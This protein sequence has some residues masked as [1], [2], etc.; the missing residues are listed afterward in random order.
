MSSQ[1]KYNKLVDPFIAMAPIVHYT[2]SVPK[3]LRW[4]F[5]IGVKVVL[6]LFAGGG[7]S[8]ELTSG[9]LTEN[10]TRL[11]QI[12]YSLAIQIVLGVNRNQISFEKILKVSEKPMG[13]FSWKTLCHHGQVLL[14]ERFAKFDYG[15]KLNMSIYG[16]K[17]SPLYDLR[18][19]N[20]DNLAVI[21]GK[22]DR[23]CREADIK[24]LKQS[25]NC[26]IKLNHAVEHNS[27]THLDFHFAKDLGHYVNR[28]VIGFLDDSK[29][30]EK[31]Q[32][33]LNPVED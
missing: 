10:L 4:P 2:D 29:K 21:Y 5:S 18:N 26:P 20:C 27:W 32:Y 13:D 14:G 15:P 28:H 1:P 25:V 12:L 30:D 6:E 9:Y 8:S 17:I 3:V 24:F 22:S 23:T 7:I 16:D 19:V 11:V 31:N 33:S